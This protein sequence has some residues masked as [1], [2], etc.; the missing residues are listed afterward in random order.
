MGAA[1]YKD[2]W[3]YLFRIRRLNPA[4]QYVTW[5]HYIKENDGVGRD[6]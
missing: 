5:V 6:T 3:E 2:W 1:W 4:S